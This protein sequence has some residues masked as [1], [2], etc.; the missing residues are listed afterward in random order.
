MA[1]F[2]ESRGSGLI[3]VILIK[4]GVKY[5]LVQ[6][7]LK[8]YRNMLRDGGKDFHTGDLRVGSRCSAP[9]RACTTEELRAWGDEDI[10]SSL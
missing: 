2:K 8:F 6:R 1:F 7:M 9:S 3:Y 4:N 5:K 10:L